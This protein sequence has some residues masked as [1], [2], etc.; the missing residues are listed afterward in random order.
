VGALCSLTITVSW[1]TGVEALT[2]DT[3]RNQNN[4]TVCQQIRD[5]HSLVVLTEKKD[6]C[7]HSVQH[8]ITKALYNIS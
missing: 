1:L 7:P 8:V 5:V 2:D 3:E 4:V 6:K